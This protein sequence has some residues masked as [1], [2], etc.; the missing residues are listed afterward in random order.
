M[1]L[2]IF[3]MNIYHESIYIPCYSCARPKRPERTSAATVLRREEEETENEPPGPPRRGD[4]PLM[5]AEGDYFLL[6]D[7]VSYPD[8]FSPLKTAQWQEEERKYVHDNVL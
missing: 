1:N 5:A 4:L 3:V 7:P 2:E 8:P 6:E